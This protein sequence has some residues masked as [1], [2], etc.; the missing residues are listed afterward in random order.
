M[1][2]T[3]GC[4]RVEEC[5]PAPVTRPS[6]TTELLNVEERLLAKNDALAA[7]VRESL[8]HPPGHRGQP[9]E[10]AGRRQDLA[11]GAHDRR[12]SGPGARSA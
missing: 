11:A 2:L 6:E 3:C 9:D 7:H 5:A 8:G 1:C 4:S 12:R 10:L